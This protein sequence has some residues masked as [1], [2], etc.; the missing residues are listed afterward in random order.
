[1]P[2]CQF[3]GYPTQLF[4]SCTHFTFVPG[5]LLRCCCTFAVITRF[6]Y[7]AFVYFTHTHAFLWFTFSF[8]FALVSLRSLVI[9]SFDVVTAVCV[10]S[11]LHVAVYLFTFVVYLRYVVTFCYARTLQLHLLPARWLLPFTFVFCRVHSYPVLHVTFGW[12]LFTRLYTHTHLLR[13][14]PLV[15]SQLLRFASC[16]ILPLFYPIYI[17]VTFTFT[18]TFI[19]LQFL[20]VP[21]VYIYF[22]FTPYLYVVTFYLYFGLLFCCFSLFT[23]DLHF[24][25]FAVRCSVRLVVCCL[26]VYLVTFVICCY[27]LR[28]YLLI[29]LLQFVTLRFTF[30]VVVHLTFTLLRSYPAYVCCS[31]LYLP[32]ICCPPHYPV[33]YELVAVVVTVICC[34]CCLRFAF[35]LHVVRLPF[36]LPFTPLHARVYVLLLLFQFPS[37]SFG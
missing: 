35:T 2:F 28:C 25:L 19:Y 27:T 11:S 18:F 17:S 33:G 16:F 31:C 9:Y 6:T 15:C 20:H 13:V 1:M 21:H 36:I 8:T 32:F 5:Y 34:I 14:Y 22:I 12:L 26:Y 23:F 4:V 3:V 37:Y 30:V 7:L 24:I 29:R 10:G